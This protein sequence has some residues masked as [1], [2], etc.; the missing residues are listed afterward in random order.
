MGYEGADDD[1]DDESEERPAARSKSSN[2]RMTATGFV[3]FRVIDRENMTETEAAQ[4]RIRN[5]ATLQQLREETLD[6][7][8]P[9]PPFGP[10]DD[11]L[12]DSGNEFHDIEPEE[13]DEEDIPNFPV[14]HPNSEA[15]ETEEDFQ[16]R[17][18]RTVTVQCDY[19]RYLADGT[20][21]WN[22]DEDDDEIW[23]LDRWEH[24]WQGYFRIEEGDDGRWYRVKEESSDA[25]SDDAESE[26][27]V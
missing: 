14:A 10:G 9:L 27:D 18:E 26:S 16:T 12:S 21:A 6:D 11:C 17:Q 5:D 7:N 23:Y 2:P 24:G 13:S 3:P 15:D 8:I 22:K 1:M 4:L 19:G 20:F 25:R